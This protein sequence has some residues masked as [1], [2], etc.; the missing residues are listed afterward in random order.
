MDQRHRRPRAAPSHDQASQIGAV[1]PWVT[2]RSFRIDQPFRRGATAAERG[3]ALIPFPPGGQGLHASKAL[4]RP[5]PPTSLLFVCR[6]HA[7]LSPMAEGLARSAY[8]HLDISVESAGLTIGPIDFRAVAVMAELGIDIG[9]TPVNSIRHVDLGAF[10][11]VVSLGIHKLAV[12]RHQVAL[13]WDIPELSRMKE[14]MAAARLREI[15]DALSARV[16][17][18]GAILTAANRA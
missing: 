15:R 10:D 16:G 8:E 5:P 14:S 4:A 11:I 9:D 6:T 1:V 17:A 2:S 18:L 12:E 7:V 13:A 3:A